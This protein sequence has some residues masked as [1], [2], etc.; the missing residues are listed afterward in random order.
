MTVLENVLVAMHS[1]TT[2]GPLG[3]V[4]HTSRSKVEERL[5]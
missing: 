5:A 1:R 3:A 4:L 2:T